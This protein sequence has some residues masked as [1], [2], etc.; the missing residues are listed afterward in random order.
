MVVFVVVVLCFNTPQRKDLSTNIF[1]CIILFPCVIIYPNKGHWSSRS[2]HRICHIKQLTR[3]N[4]SSTISYDTIRS[5]GSSLISFKIRWIHEINFNNI[6]SNLTRTTLSEM[7][8]INTEKNHSS[9]IYAKRHTWCSKCDKLNQ[10]I[11][12][13][14]ADEQNNNQNNKQYYQ[15]RP[16]DIIELSS[17]YFRLYKQLRIGNY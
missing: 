4:S 12:K 2:Y 17:F 6:Y 5:Q 3:F 9:K 14:I 13:K 7:R 10:T 1:K 16:G 11:T 8:I 15:P